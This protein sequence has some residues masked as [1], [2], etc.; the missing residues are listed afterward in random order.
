M[1]GDRRHDA[2]LKSSGP[3]YLRTLLGSADEAG[4]LAALRAAT[5]S[6]AQ[7][8]ELLTSELLFTDRLFMRGHEELSAMFGGGVGISQFPAHAVRWENV[9]SDLAVWV[10]EA[11]LTRF[12]ARAYNFARTEKLFAMQHWRL[13]P[14]RYRLEVRP[15]QT[16]AL[17][18]WSREVKLRHRGDSIPLA[19]PSGRELVVAMTQLET[20]PWNPAT[21]PDLAAATAPSSATGKPVRWEIHNLGC[22]PAKDVSVQLRVNDEP[23]ET[24]IIAEVPPVRDYKI[25]TVTVSFKHDGPATGMSLVVDPQDQIS[26]ITEQNNRSDRRR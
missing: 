23:V 5:F 9:G 19:L 13:Q 1:T 18:L 11:T 26:E 17:P 24:Q 4:V 10:Q 20:F 2:F 25:G 21:L 22:V 7:N 14:G 3:A 15:N 12:R 6:N 16:G 8:F